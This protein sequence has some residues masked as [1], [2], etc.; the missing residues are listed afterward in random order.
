MSKKK[1]G[2]RK[3]ARR[4]HDVHGMMQIMIDLKPKR[5]LSE[6]FINQKVDVTN[7]V[8]Y[9]EELKKTDSYK[10][11][12]ITL[13]HLFSM[14][15]AKTMYNRPLLNRFVANRHVYEH[16]DISLSFVSKVAFDD[17]SKEVMIII[18]VNPEDKLGDISTKIK[19]K[20]AGFR[21]F[22]AKEEGANGAIEVLGKLPNIIRIPII[23]FIKFLDKVG[24]LPSSL[25]QD[26]VYYSS[27]LVTDIGVLKCGG[28]YHNVTD[29]GT[30]SGIISIG[31]V[32]KEIVN[33]EEKYFCEF[34]V[35]IDERIADGFY[36]IKS[37]HFIE[38]LL[39]NPKLLE[40]RADEKIEIN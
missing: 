22:T 28:I 14:A 13:F 21:N 31:E 4:V 5:S 37:I 30:C 9:L 35:T 33:G 40:G 26:N 8:N 36:F 3:D 23:A 6:L 17:K 1:F 24:Y 11:N 25:V 15:I 39:N 29:F 32:K 10:E 34:G 38:Y 12:K 27:M 7:L 19:D 16:N 18:P 2:D 20:V